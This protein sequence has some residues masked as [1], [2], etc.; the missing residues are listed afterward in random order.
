MCLCFEA[1]LCVCV[2]VPECRNAHHFSTDAQGQK[3]AWDFLQ[4]GLGL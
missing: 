1:I 4:V 2:C 3:R